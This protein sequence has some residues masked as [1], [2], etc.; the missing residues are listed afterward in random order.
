[1]NSA[2]LPGA[3]S[4]PDVQTAIVASKA[5][6]RLPALLAYLPPASRLAPWPRAVVWLTATARSR[7]SGPGAEAVI[8]RDLALDSLV[9]PARRQRRLAPDPLIAA[10]PRGYPRPMGPALSQ[11]VNTET[12]IAVLARRSNQP[13]RPAAP[14]RKSSLSLRR[15]LHRW[16]R[17]TLI[18][19]V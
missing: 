3:A 9:A 6:T 16:Y 17:N 4:V 18:G 5:S 8:G 13:G 12:V 10:M 2:P 19:Q 15:R 1:M 11:P 7:A 14:R